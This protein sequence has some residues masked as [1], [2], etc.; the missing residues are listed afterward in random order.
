[1]LTPQMKKNNRI[2]IF[3]CMLITCQDSFVFSQQVLVDRG[4]YIENLWCFPMASDTSA[5]VYLPNRARLALDEKQNPKFSYLRYVINKPTEQNTNRSIVEADG[6]GILHFLVLYDTPEKPVRSAEEILKK[7]LNNKEVKLRGPI[8]FDKGSYLLVSSI[9]NQ[10]SGKEERKILAKGEAPVLENSSIALS[11]SLTPEKSKL[12]L[13]SLKMPTPDVSIVFD[14]GFSGLTEAYDAELEV[15]WSEV[16]KSQAFKAGGSVYFVGADIEVGF[17]KMRKDNAI[18]LTVNGSS[19]MLEGLLNTVY[20]RLLNLLFTPIKEEKA[21][22]QGGLGS[23]LNELLKPDGALGSRNT[24]GF[25]INVNYQLKD[26]Q[27]SGTS[28]LFFKGKNQ[29]DRH[30]YVTFN[31]G[32][33]FQNYGNNTNYFKDVPLWDPTFQQREIFVSVDGDMEKEFKKILNGVTIILNKKHQSGNSTLKNVVINKET[34]KTLD[35][36][37]SFVYGYDGDTN[38][39]DWMNYEYKTIWQFQGGVTKEMS[40]DSSKASMINLYTPFNRKKIVLDGNMEMLKSLGIRSI[41]VKIVYDF[42]GKR[43]EEQNTIRLGDNISEK[44]FEITLPTQ[45]EDIEYEIIWFKNDMTKVSK[46]GKDSYGLIFI[47]DIPK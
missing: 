16:K 23:A 19:T 26:I 45:I 31:I 21:E 41:V 2:K 11:F 40:W 20:Q 6:G 35:K 17:E 18:K 4:I 46:K 25:G 43:K 32:N 15:N 37:L 1:M 33:I 44:T 36:P 22:S 39:L 7:K 42:F 28:H 12:L 10:E 47:D 24:T 38:R 5:Y 27:S 13:E 30:H 29:V 14:L 3:L 34:F 8:I 9:L